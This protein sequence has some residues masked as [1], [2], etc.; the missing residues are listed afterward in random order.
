[1]CLKSYFRGEEAFKLNAMASQIKVLIQ[2]AFANFLRPPSA[3]C[4]FIRLTAK[5]TKDAQ[6]SAKNAKSV[7]HC[8]GG[9][10]PKKIT[11][12]KQLC[13]WRYN[14]SINRPATAPWY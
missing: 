10:A 11:G 3:L 5:N 12:Q 14:R 2:F 7:W 1:M 13:A 4:G 9:S 8:A 6:R